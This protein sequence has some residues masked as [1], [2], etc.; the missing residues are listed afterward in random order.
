[1]KTLL[2]DT[3]LPGAALTALLRDSFPQAHPATL[4]GRGDAGT[5]VY[6]VTFSDDAERERFCALLRA[7]EVELGLRPDV[8]S[9]RP[10]RMYDLVDSFAASPAPTFRRMVWPVRNDNA[11]ATPQPR[12][13]ARKPGNYSYSQRPQLPRQ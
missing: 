9:R 7:V 10:G 5:Q 1:M 3:R 2:F 4:L 8:P 13:T 6:S 12:G 11:A